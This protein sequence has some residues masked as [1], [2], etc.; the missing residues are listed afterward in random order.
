MNPYDSGRFCT[1]SLESAAKRYKTLGFSTI[2]LNGARNPQ[3]SK[4]PTIKWARFQHRHPSDE[5][6]QSWFSNQP[7]V[8]IGIVCGRVS[9]LMVLD[10]DSETGASEFRHLCS[11]LVDTFTVRSGT[12]KLPHFYYRLAEGKLIPTSAYPGVDLRGEGSYVVAPP[13]RVG[14]AI[15]HVENDVPIHEVSEFDLRRIMRFLAGR[16]VVEVEQSAVENVPKA[17]VSEFRHPLSDTDLLAYYRQH[18]ANGRNQALFRTAVLAR[19]MGITEAIFSL[20]LASVHATEP[21]A[22]HEPYDTRYAEAIRTIASAYSRPARQKVSMAKGLGITVREWFMEHGLVNV[23]RVLDGLYAVG[24]KANEQFTELQACQKLAVLRIGRRSIM[25]ALKSIIGDWRLFEMA[26]SPLNPPVPANAAIGSEDL[27]NS[28]E[29]SRG[30]KRVKNGRGRPARVYQLPSPCMLAAKIGVQ[31]KADD[32]LSNQDFGSPKA[33]R[34]ALHTELLSR[35]PGYY[36]RKWL[37]D[38]LGVSR[39]TARRYEQAADIHVQPAY[40]TRTLSWGIASTLPQK[41]VDSPKGVFIEA[42]DGKRYPAIRGL[43][44]RLM[45]L[46]RMPILKHQQGNFYSIGAVG[47]GIPTPIQLLRDEIKLH[48]EQG[49]DTVKAERKKQTVGIPTPEWLAA[50][51][52]QNNPIHDSTITEAKSIEKVGVGIPTPTQTEPSFWLCP[53]C[54]NF[55]ITTA[56]PSNCSRCNASCEWEI[57]PPIIWRDA[58][59]LKQWWQQRYREYQKLKYQR[60]LTPVAQV[61]ETIEMSESAKGLI[62]RLHKQIPNLSFANARNIVQQF[63]EQLIERA[64]TVIKGRSR[65][66][67]PAGFLVSF[68]RSESKIL[69]N[70]KK[71]VVA[72]RSEKGESGMEWLRRFA[73]SEYLNFISN[74]DDI[75]NMHLDQHNVGA[76][77]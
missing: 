59:A 58:Q 43:A 13:T 73:K 35:R 66:R 29:M 20:K 36:G 52:T 68:L 27:Y 25:T 7:N 32:V 76:E 18:C 69:L 28:C 46:G 45:K 22:E 21:G 48:H 44:L 50:F 23:A 1:E 51:R 19:D 5:E 33:Y 49:L 77:A 2:P 26:V 24:M 3:Q 54:L 57:L 70:N 31:G 17:G 14:E 4:L 39:W 12:R 10:F 37:S 15:W 41:A 60:S 42:S 6:L 63:S 72:V 11:D 71:S 55:H 75:L 64:L 38:R 16:K 9:R 67:S 47:I 74:A 53:E 56:R 8:G 40:V 65:L 34:Q 62:E 30:A 61:D